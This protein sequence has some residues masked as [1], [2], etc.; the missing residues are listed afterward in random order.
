[1][2]NI[3][4][5]L[6]TGGTGNIGCAI[7]EELIQHNYR[8]YILCRS[9]E[10][11]KKAKAL[12]AHS[13]SG[14]IIEPSKWLHQLDSMDA[15]IHTA[16]GFEDNMGAIDKN[17]MEAIVLSQKKWKEKREEKLIFLYTTG[18]WNFG[19]HREVITENSDKKSIPEFQ[20][21]LDSSTFLKA[22]SC[23][24]TRLVSPVNVVSEELSFAPQIL[25]WE[26]EKHQRPCIPDVA[27][28]I[29]SLVDRYNL[30]EL[31]RLALEK[32]HLGEEYIGT[33]SDVSV[34][35][36]AQ[37]L[38]S[39]SVKKVPLDHWLETYGSWSRGYGLKQTFSNAKAVDQLGWQPKN[40]VLDK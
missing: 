31:Y 33:A 3:Q 4:S 9:D 16:C 34:E 8:V 39:Q 20:W 27:N 14:D 24:D 18:C 1:M 25:H 35:Q 10:S 6:V 21:M 32:G 12:G 22:N 29:W 23:V 28:L 19:N 13:I 30:A 2:K 38:S 36:L 37:Q 7:V 26:L 40:I 17:L 5:V 15:L 11:I